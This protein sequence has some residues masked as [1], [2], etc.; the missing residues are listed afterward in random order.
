MAFPL[1]GPDAEFPG[2]SNKLEWRKAEMASVNANCSA[3]G[4]TLFSHYHPLA[5]EREYV[6]KGLGHK[7][8]KFL[9][10]IKFNEYFLYIRKIF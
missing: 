7:M 4:K 1:K 9:R 6:I 5:S 2:D 10:P 8:N 3:R